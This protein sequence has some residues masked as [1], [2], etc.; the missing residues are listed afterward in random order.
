M[1]TSRFNKKTEL[2]QNQLATSKIL[3]TMLCKHLTGII[4]V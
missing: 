4:D 3:F 1:L 2:H